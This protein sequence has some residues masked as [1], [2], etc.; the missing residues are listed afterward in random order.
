MITVGSAKEWIPELVKR[1]SE[2][3]VG[4]G[5][6][7]TTDVGPVISPAARDRIKGLITQSIDEGAEVLLDGRNVSVDSMPD[8]NWVGPTVLRGSAKN[9]GYTTE[10]FG[11]ALYVLEAES[12]DEAV[13]IINAN[14]WGNGASIYT[15]SGAAAR[16]FTHN[17]EPGQIGVNVPIPVPVPT[18]S[19]SGNKGSFRGDVPFYGPQGLHFYLQNKTVTSLWKVGDVDSTRGTVSMPVHH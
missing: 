3:H 4:S 1:A 9:V 10:L 16:Y 2:L 11:P 13:E 14:A 6:D 8:G 19:W 15:S 18:F 17:A 12:L 7:S 5:F